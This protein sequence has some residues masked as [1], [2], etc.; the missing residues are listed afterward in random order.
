LYLVIGATVSLAAAGL[1]VPSIE[2]LREQ[3]HLVVGDADPDRQA[4]EEAYWRAMRR[5]PRIRAVEASL[6][7]AARGGGDLTAPRV[8]REN[9]LYAYL[10]LM[11]RLPRADS[12]RNGPAQRPDAPPAIGASTI[13]PSLGPGAATTHPSPALGALSRPAEDPGLAGQIR[14]LKDAPPVR[15]YAGGTGRWRW[16]RLRAAR[17][18][19]RQAALDANATDLRLGLL[20][21]PVIRRLAGGLLAQG[22]AWRE[23]GGGR[24]RSRPMRRRRG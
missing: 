17:L 15:L 14:E 22:A 12:R 3:V 9:G 1:A 7:D 23:A 11:A 21:R 8:D 4:A 5:E 13:S 24:V 2:R 20:Y 19:A 18:P 10:Q 16:M 6:R